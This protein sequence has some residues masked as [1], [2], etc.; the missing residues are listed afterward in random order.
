MKGNAPGPLAHHTTATHGEKIYL[1]GGIKPNGST[2]KTLYEF[3]IASHTWSI[4]KREGQVPDECDE[5]SSCLTNDSFVIF[6]GF[7][8]G[9]RTNDLYQF[10]FADMTWTKLS[11][12]QMAPSARA[13]ASITFTNGILVAFGGKDEDNQRLNDIW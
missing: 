11:T 6:G 3:D 2:N 12:S 8:G 9:V 4:V 13:G 10:S 5:H 1:F 7:H